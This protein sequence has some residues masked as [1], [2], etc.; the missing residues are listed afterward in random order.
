M[1]I[2]QKVKDYFNSLVERSILYAPGVERPQYVSIVEHRREAVISNPKRALFSLIRFE[3]DGLSGEATAAEVD[4]LEEII[5]PE[6]ISAMRRWS[7]SNSAELPKCS[8]AERGT[9][10]E[11][12]L[13][14]A[15]FGAA[16]L[17]ADDGWNTKRFRRMLKRIKR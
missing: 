2:K 12:I 13:L 11:D 4:S 14:L 7:Q 10:A 15:A 3:L 8:A 17:T 1:E 5:N 6:L 9:L 16:V